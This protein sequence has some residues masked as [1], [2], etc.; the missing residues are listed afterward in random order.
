MT[1]LLDTHIPIW[2]H[3]VQSNVYILSKTLPFKLIILLKS[4]GKCTILLVFIISFNLNYC[5]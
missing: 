1:T 2:S 3:V 4:L 5:L